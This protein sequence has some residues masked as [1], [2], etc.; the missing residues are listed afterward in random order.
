M[1]RTKHTHIP[2][3][4]CPAPRTHG[5]PPTRPAPTPTPTPTSTLARGK[6]RGGGRGA[7]ARGERGIGERGGVS[8]RSAPGGIAGGFSRCYYHSGP[9][10]SPFGTQKRI[11]ILV[12]RCAFVVDK[13]AIDVSPKL[14][15]WILLPA[16]HACH[17]EPAI[18]LH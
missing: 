14:E 4:P 6:A 11:N 17:G 12:V 8:A 13:I 5:L 9:C 1:I 7:T 18:V 2:R 15:L 10:R 3:T 16:R